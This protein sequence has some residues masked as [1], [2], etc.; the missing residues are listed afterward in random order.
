MEYYNVDDELRNRLIKEAQRDLMPDGA[1]KTCMIPGKYSRECTD[2]FLNQLAVFFGFDFFKNKKEDVLSK[3]EP[4][5][6]FKS[7]RDYIEETGRPWLVDDKR[8]ITDVTYKLSTDCEDGEKSIHQFEDM[9]FF[10]SLIMN[11]KRSID[12]FGFIVDKEKKD[13][14]G[15]I[16]IKFVCFYDEYNSIFD[17]LNGL[18]EEQ[19]YNVLRAL[20]SW[21]DS[22]LYREFILSPIAKYVRDR[23]VERIQQFFLRQNNS[24]D[25]P[26]AQCWRFSESETFQ[27]RED[28]YTKITDLNILSEIRKLLDEREDSQVITSEEKKRE[29]NSISNM[30]I[31]DFHVQRCFEILPPIHQKNLKRR[32]LLSDPKKLEEFMTVMR[33]KEALLYEALSEEERMNAKKQEYKEFLDQYVDQLRHDPKINPIKENES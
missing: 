26:A 19:Y 21:A 10:D 2:F 32:E 17:H 18:N 4:T 13:E 1:R 29:L 5:Q 8:A 27:V 31:F 25:K 3:L 11:N 28:D 23:H 14:F 9:M 20:S 16:P 33:K 6:R 30:S 15:E 22:N 24:S 12:N 7:L